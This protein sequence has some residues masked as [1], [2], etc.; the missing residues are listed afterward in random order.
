M[1]RRTAIRKDTSGGLFTRRLAACV[2]PLWSPGTARRTTSIPAISEIC[3]LCR[4]E[5]VGCVPSKESGELGSLLQRIGLVC[6]GASSNE[7]RCMRRDRRQAGI[8]ATGRHR[9]CVVTPIIITLDAEP[10]TMSV[11]PQ[12]ECLLASS[13]AAGSGAQGERSQLSGSAHEEAHRADGRF[14]LLSPARFRPHH[15]GAGDCSACANT[16]AWKI[17][18]PRPPEPSLATA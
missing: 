5:V 10:S 14:P 2:A 1:R 7:P 9:R 15:P 6:R 13:P 11:V 3:G 16:R 8:R 12:L 4:I 18:A 17:V